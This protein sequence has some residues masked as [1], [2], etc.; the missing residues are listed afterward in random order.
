M[1]H[2][3][4]WAHALHPAGRSIDVCEP[5]ACPGSADVEACARG[6]PG[7][8]SEPVP[9]CWLNVRTFAAARGD[10]RP[11]LAIL[12]P[13]AALPGTGRQGGFCQFVTAGR[14]AETV[15]LELLNRLERGKSYLELP[16]RPARAA[17]RGTPPK[18]TY[19]DTIQGT[20]PARAG[21]ARNSRGRLFGIG[22]IL[23]PAQS[24]SQAAGAV[25][26][27]PGTPCNRRCCSG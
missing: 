11:A 5:P 4:L 19:S 25:A 3:G 12:T 23:S 6:D 17:G 9:G 20:I 10:P 14:Y 18:M 1:I 21:N 8:C 15:Q 16:R 2:P 22:V 13:F 24:S 27:A 7:E 26:A